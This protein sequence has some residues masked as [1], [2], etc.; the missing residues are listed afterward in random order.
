MLV[1]GDTAIK[2]VHNKIRISLYNDDFN[3][4]GPPNFTEFATHT[5]IVVDGTAGLRYV[6]D[7]L[8]AEIGDLIKHPR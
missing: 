4:N 7:Y 8:T 6:P 2:P 5:A 3:M 1:K